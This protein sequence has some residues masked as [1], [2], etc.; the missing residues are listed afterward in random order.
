MSQSPVQHQ[1]FIHFAPI[2]TGYL[3][4]MGRLYDFTF[5]IKWL[6]ESGIEEADLFDDAYNRSIQNEI[7]KTHMDSEFRELVIVC[8]NFYLG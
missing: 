6:V 1:P 8:L 2:P 4:G 5:I 3:K 7:D